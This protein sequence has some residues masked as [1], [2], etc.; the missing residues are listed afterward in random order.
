MPSRS[1]QDR[2]SLAPSSWQAVSSSLDWWRGR[3]LPRRAHPM[4]CS[5]RRSL[6]TF[7]GLGRC[8]GL[9]RRG[10]ST[11]PGP[12]RAEPSPSNAFVTVALYLFVA[13]ARISC[14]KACS[15]TCSRVTTCIPISILTSSLSGNF[16][17]SMF[18]ASD[19]VEIFEMAAIQAADYG[20]TCEAARWFRRSPTEVTTLR[21]RNA[22]RSRHLSVC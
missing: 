20:D 9:H 7:L 5:K 1:S 6:A 19:N 11:A 12:K 14:A 4:P 21:A 10:L 2:S 8:S 22:L 16:V 18:G 3:S 17:A 15:L 13:K